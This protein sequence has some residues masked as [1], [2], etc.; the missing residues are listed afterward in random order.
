VNTNNIS[1]DLK[2]TFSIDVVSKLE[3]I[4][5]DSL[6]ITISDNILEK[7]KQIGLD[8]DSLYERKVNAKRRV[9]LMQIFDDPPEFFK[10]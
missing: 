6:S 2:N 9:V 4:L 10:K 5:V 1:D 3:N 7:V 8:G